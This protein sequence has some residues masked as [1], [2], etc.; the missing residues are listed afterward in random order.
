MTSARWLAALLAFAQFGT[1]APALA[2]GLDS[3]HTLVTSVEAAGEAEL[4]VVG[5]IE[6]GPRKYRFDRRRQPMVV[7]PITAIKGELPE[8]PIELVGLV[9]PVG[10]KPPSTWPLCNGVGFEQG[11]MGL[12]FLKREQEGWGPAGDRYFAWSRPVRS[13][14]DP[15]LTAVRLYLRLADLPREQQAAAMS[16]ERDSLLTSADAGS[17]AVGAILDKE[18]RRIEEWEKRRDPAP[19]P[20]P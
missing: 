6:S 15:M 18:L 4:I 19:T 5:R 2:C 14:R 10:F 20:A 13:R 17:R 7:R 11:S 12:F 8:K 16:A 1:A 9:S 3:R